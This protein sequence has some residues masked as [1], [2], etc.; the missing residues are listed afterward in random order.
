[1]ASSKIHI[2]VCPKIHIQDVSFLKKSDLKLVIEMYD[3][4][5]EYF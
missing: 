4:A 1:M 5:K 2:L 3:L